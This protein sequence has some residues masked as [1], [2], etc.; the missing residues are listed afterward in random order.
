M[1]LIIELKVKETDRLQQDLL[2]LKALSQ[3][4]ELDKK[5][6]DRVTQLEN[7]IIP[8]KK[9]KMIHDKCDYETDNVYTWES[10]RPWNGGQRF[11]EKRVSFF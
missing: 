10:N 4:A 3:F 2:P 11:E 5:L 7:N 9:K 6:N 1:G 8:G